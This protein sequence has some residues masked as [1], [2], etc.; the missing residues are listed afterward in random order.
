[1]TQ[2]GLDFLSS[3]FHWLMDRQQFTGTAPRL[4]R[5]YHL[6]LTEEQLSLLSGFSLFVLPGA[7]ALVGVFFAFRRRR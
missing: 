5:Y 7:A 3:S 4:K 6:N 2:E 1:M